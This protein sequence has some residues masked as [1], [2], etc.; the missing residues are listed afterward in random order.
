MNNIEDSKQIY[1]YRWISSGMIGTVLYPLNQLKTV[2]PKIYYEEVKKYIGREKLLDTEITPLDCRWG[3]V[4]FL[5]AV[6]PKVIFRNLRNAGFDYPL[7]KFYK[8]PLS[9]FSQENLCAMLYEKIDDEK[10]T[11]IFERF[12]PL[13]IDQYKIILDATLE[14]YKEKKVEGKH[15]LV[16]HLIPHVLYKGTLDVSKLEIVEG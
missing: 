6:D 15:P 16:Y 11:K 7:T 14:Y 12:D 8:I 4:I 10:P 13:K 2:F 9:A 1:L 3:D 5:T